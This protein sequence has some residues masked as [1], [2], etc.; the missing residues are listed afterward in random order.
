[1]TIFAD[2]FEAATGH[3]PFPY[4]RRLAKA[5]ELPTLLNIPTGCGKTAAVI[6][7]WLWRRRF[8][9]PEVREAS[10]SPASAASGPWVNVVDVAVLGRAP[11][12]TACFCSRDCAIQPPC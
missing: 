7:G 10:C 8:A 4:Q 2:C 5:D 11:Q 12:Q 3:E 6:L 1:M 9:S